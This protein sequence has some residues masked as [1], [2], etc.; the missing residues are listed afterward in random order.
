MSDNPVLE[1]EAISVEDV[2]YNDQKGSEPEPKPTDKTPV[3]SDQSEAEPKLELVEDKAKPEVKGDAETDTDDPGKVTQY[4]ELDGKEH[5]LEEVKQWRDGHLMQRDYTKKTTALAEDRKTFDAERTTER[6]TLLKAKAEISELRDQLTVLVEEDQGTDWEALK[7]D[8]PDRYIELKEKLDKRKAALEK[9]KA[10]ATPVDDPAMIQAERAKLY[11]ANPEWFEDGKPTD[12][13]KADTA[14]I[15]NYAV[16]AGFQAEEFA[17]LTRAHYL[18]TI[19]K[20]A[21]YDQL[22]EKTRE[23]KEAREKVPVTLKPKGKTTEPKKAN[24]E[25]FYG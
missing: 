6:E 8:D 10:E 4:L 16:K 25:V 21:K 14:L 5:D 15:Q 7:A 1:T 13:Y 9:V 2:F 17:T 18:T 22:Q 24:H 23:I 19:L 3:T 20:A 11:E 12:L